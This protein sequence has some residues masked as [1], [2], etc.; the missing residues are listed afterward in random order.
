M[1]IKFTIVRKEKIG[2]KLPT[3]LYNSSHIVGFGTVVHLAPF[4]K[5]SLIKDRHALYSKNLLRH[6]IG[7][8]IISF[9]MT[10][11]KSLGIAA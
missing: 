9:P 10:R 7:A 11:S 4:A 2:N 5:Y 1:V 8:S 3:K 6:A